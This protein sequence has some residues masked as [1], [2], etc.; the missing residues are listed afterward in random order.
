[1][2]SNLWTTN[3]IVDEQSRNS[4]EYGMAVNTDRALP[5]A[6]DGFKPVAKRSVYDMW[7][8]G[9]TSSK[10]HRK[11]ARIVG[12]TMGK[13]H[14]HGDSSI[15]GAIVRLAQ[16]W[17][18][19]YPIFDGHGNFGNIGGDGPAAMRYTE[20][21]LTKLAE[22]G[23]L[24]GI[25]K[26]N[27][28]FIPNYDET[29][30]EPVV[31]PSIFPNLLCNPNEGIGWAM[32]CSWAPH[33]LGEVA[34][35]I[36]TYMDGGEPML[37]GP[38][39][40]TGG[41]V[42]NKN[43]IP[44][45]MKTGHGSVK[46]RGKYEVK[47]QEI[48]FT[49]VPY[50]TRIENLMAQIGKGCDSGD[51]TNVVDIR[52]E[53]DKNGVRLVIEVDKNTNPELIVNK[54]FAKTDLQS[55][56]S[57]NQLALVDKTPTELNLKD[58]CKVYVDH[59]ISC[60]IKEA[61]YDLE[62]AQDRLH[63][64]EGLLKA[65]ED[66]DNII[67]LIKKSAS[68]AVAKESLMAKYKF[69][70]AQAK[71]ILAMRLS[72]LANLEKV[73]LQN[74]QAELVNNIAHF[75]ALVSD[76]TTQKGELRNRLAEIVKKFGDA[77][78]TELAQIEVSKEDKEIAYVEPEKCVVVMNESGLIKRIPTASFRTQKRNGK[79]VKTQDD[80]VS[81]VIRTNTVD[82]LMVFTDQ[83]RL[84]RILVDNIPVGTNAA[85]GTSLHQLLEMQENEHPSVI[86]SIY[87]DTDANYV[88]FVT[89]NGL[90]KKTSL[91]EYIKTKKKTGIA[92][93]SLKE[94][95]TLA[96]VSL[97]KDEDIIL[98]TAGGMGIRF[99]S[100]EVA[101]TSR[102][103]SG[104]KGMNLKADDYVVAA[105][106]VRHVEDQVA[107]F[108][109]SGLGKKFPM[110]E[111]PVQKRAG[112]GLICYKPTDATGRVTAGALLSDE[113]SI[114]LIGDKSS[115]CIA[116]TEVPSLSRGSIGNQLIKNGKIYSVSKV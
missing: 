78:R 31:L 3:D 2:Q 6:A 41:I 68:A 44:N 48:I 77:R 21:R 93:I 27:V 59:N 64:V 36:Y 61:K 90:V 96:S 69:T 100:T 25:K 46:V 10:P 32:G 110:N 65:L 29:E 111:L 13:Y 92:A 101:P 56:F 22:E 17:V 76:E 42:I 37:P 89:K 109:Q 67:A 97:V 1:M 91:D 103:T 19:R 108:V 81:T 94:G 38:D 80:I 51:I 116:A 82:S 18:M 74:E 24:A 63:I 66:I 45:I 40:P 95:D 60:I 55:S 72:S 57:Y 12:D 58:C 83:G 47:G 4:L 99:S 112:K 52:N 79:G 107:V 104:V 54:L 50:G 14:P 75:K 5:N 85:K 23:L 28:D 88:L 8:T 34:E 70:E 7:E 20:I 71:A 39:F 62:K 86:Y 11:S 30:E 113:D 43:D 16:P 15:Y 87:R 114:L 106:P 115:I 105:M 102:A 33:N 9:T 84:Y 26:K 53:G 73:E 98:L 35:A 49:E